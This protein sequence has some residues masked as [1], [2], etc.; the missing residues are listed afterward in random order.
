MIYFLIYEHAIGRCPHCKSKSVIFDPM[1]GEYVCTKCGT[2]IGDHVVDFGK[3]WRAF[4]PGESQLKSRTGSSLTLAMHDRGFVTT[5]S[6]KGKGLS[7]TF[8]KRVREL[9]RIQRRSRIEKKDKNEVTALRFLNEYVSKLQLPPQVREEA[10]RI[11]RKAIERLNVKKK[12]MKAMA[13]S[14]IL[15]ACRV[16]S[17]PLTLR[18]IARQLG[19]EEGDLWKAER[20]ILSV[21]KDVTP[22][23]LEPKD[24]IPLIVNRLGL[25]S[26]VQYFAA[27][28]TYLARKLEIGCGRGPVGLAAASVYVASIL[29]DEKKTQQDVARVCNVTD[30]TIR[31]RY[32]DLIEHFDIEVRL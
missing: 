30:V 1:R 5:F 25:S 18:S 32:G 9:Q 13:A 21:V 31:N 28:L 20:K 19:F 11:L 16:Y 14:S 17:I 23:M 26:E 4:E 15:L 12:T 27:Y 3:E 10:A 24:F 22:K 6:T 2:V 8:K 7:K 29:L